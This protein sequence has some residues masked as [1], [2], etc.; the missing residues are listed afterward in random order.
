MGLL[1]AG[2]WRKAAASAADANVL[3]KKWQSVPDLW[4]TA[5]LSLFKGLTCLPLPPQNTKTVRNKNKQKTSCLASNYWLLA[6]T[7]WILGPLELQSLDCFR[8]L[9]DLL[10]YTGDSSY[11]SR[12]L[13]VK[14]YPCWLGFSHGNTKRAKKSRGL[15][16]LSS[17][18]HGPLSCWASNFVRFFLPLLFGFK[19]NTKATE[20]CEWIIHPWLFWRRFGSHYS[21][22]CICGSL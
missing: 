12:V 5:L 8:A 4:R 21:K 15:L 13:C 7:I 20:T 11:F 9:L 3:K 1:T 18:A 22:T 10:T 17:Q 14:I 6:P 2:C 19:N 16:S